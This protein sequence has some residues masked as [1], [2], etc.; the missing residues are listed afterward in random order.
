M[1]RA[2][3]LYVAGIAFATSIGFAAL[4]GLAAGSGGGHI[5]LRNLVCVPMLLVVS[6]V[7]SLPLGVLALRLTSASGRSSNLVVAHCGA[8]FAGA[9]VL[10]LLAPL[11]ALYQLSSAW[12]GP[13]VAVGT[14]LVAF[15]CGVAVLVRILG[16]LG[17]RGPAI[18]LP[19]VLLLA[20]QVASL[21]QLAALAPPVMPSR[22]LFGRGIDGAV[23]VE[24]TP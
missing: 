16:K 23:S 8:T 17:S 10:V 2:E 15:A 14:V 5:A 22:T 4:W 12:A 3:R 1:S 11:L 13:L 6:M 7:A 21:A 24:Q 19:V 20:I 18:A 9:L